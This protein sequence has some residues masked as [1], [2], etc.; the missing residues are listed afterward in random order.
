[1]RESR[2]F[3]SKDNRHMV[4]IPKR[5]STTRAFPAPIRNQIAHAVRAEH[6]PAEFD[7]RVA[8]VGVANGADGYFLQS[9]VSD[10]FKVD[11]LWERGGFGGETYPP[12]RL[13]IR[14]SHLRSFGLL[15]IFE[16]L[17]RIFQPY[18]GLF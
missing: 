12:I 17:L 15:Q 14:G 13:S 4:P 18:S 5:P 10:T 8:D 11:I 2:D 9:H 6:V 3:L 1:M 7:R 16:A